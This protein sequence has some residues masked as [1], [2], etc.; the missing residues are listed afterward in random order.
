MYCQIHTFWE[1]LYLINVFCDFGHHANHLR[2][3]YHL[4]RQ[5][6]ICIQLKNESPFHPL[7]LYIVYH[8]LFFNQEVVATAIQFLVVALN[9][10]RTCNNPH[11]FIKVEFTRHRLQKSGT[12]Y[13]RLFDLLIIVHLFWFF[14]RGRGVFS[15]EF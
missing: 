12:S 3:A 6:R 13:T 1:L 15:R 11:I 5:P 2:P 8:K 7:C 10:F 9:G 4:I 14:F